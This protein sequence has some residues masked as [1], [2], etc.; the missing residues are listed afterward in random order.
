MATNIIREG[1]RTQASLDLLYHVSRELASAFELRLVLERVIK[2]SL[3]NV[4]GSSGSI[5]VLDDQGAPVDSIIVVG[6]KVIQETNEQLRFTLDQGLAGWVRKNRQAALIP[7]TSRDARWQPPTRADEAKAGK[8][9]VAAP[10]IVRE[11]LVGVLTLTHPEPGFFTE[12][13]LNL[14]QAISDQAGFALLNARYYA[15]SQRRAA[16][17]TAIADSA[18]AIGA[19]LQLDEVLQT[20]LDQTTRALDVE[21]VSLA[22]V[23]ANGKELVFRAATGKQSQKIIGLRV[24]MGQGIAGWVAEHGEGIIVR[25]TEKDPRFYSKVD[26]ATGFKT[27]AVA[28]APIRA[29][30]KVIGVLEA[31]NPL[32]GNFNSGDLPE[33]EGIGNLAGTAIEHAQLFEQMEAARSRYREL[34]EDSIDPILITTLDGRIIEANRQAELLIGFDKQTLQ[35][36]NVHHF[37]QADYKALGQDLAKLKENRAVSYESV[38]RGKDNNDIYIDVYVHR[39]EVDGEEQLQWILRDITE[40]KNLDSLRE[41]LSS[42]IYHDLRSPLANVVSGLDVLEMM[43]PA[44][45]DP[46]IKSVLD[47]AMRS[48]ERVQRLVNSLLDTSR[49]EA[50]QRL[51]NPEP[52]QVIDLVQSALDA[53]GPGAQGK[54]VTLEAAVPKGLPKVM[55]DGEMIRRVFINLI[56]NAIKYSNEGMKITVGAKRAGDFVE[57]WVKD[58]ARGIPKS[59]QERIFEKFARVQVGAT[60]KTKGLGLGLAYCK[61]AVEGH[62]GKIWV[63]SEVG[64][65]SRFAFTLPTART[66]KLE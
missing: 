26:E 15:E 54:E 42:M 4:R 11:K 40:R 3:E 9:V 38:L 61:L 5:I 7:D 6:S 44:D 53:V 24:R 25:E 39:I 27:R 22:L 13:H 29:K 36:M 45:Q 51:G 20:I 14:I 32:A 46:T 28:C 58:E 62:G 19:S 43:L 47:I 48:T 18:R 57:L 52:T 21:A 50:G 1:G 17:M 49:M 2:L 34:F 56:E 33:L 63:E 30:N 12:D 31:L 8:S 66:G 60:G 41:D 16:V 35:Q 37:H 10:L 55:A 59:D 23:E 65:G 64:K